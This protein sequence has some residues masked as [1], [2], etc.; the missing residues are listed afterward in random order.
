[1]TDP[2][3]HD[4]V[5]H[6]T[7]VRELD[8]DLVVVPDG[9]VQLVPNIGVI[10][11]RDA[12]L[13]VETGL[14]PRNAEKV[15]EFAAEYARGRRIYLTTTHFH[16]E[17]AFGAQAFTGEATFLVNRA[18]AE[19]LKVKGAG[20][21]DMFRGLGAPV[22]HQLEG[23]VLPEPDLIYDDSYDL[24]LGG[25]VVQLRATGRAHS[26]GDQVVRVPDAGVLFTGDLVEAGQFAIFPWF[27]P[28]DTDVSGTRW[29]AV[30]ERLAGEGAR[31]VV[32]G[33]GAIG[34]PELLADVRDYLRLLRDETWVRRD[35]AM[36]EETIVE[37]VRA[38]MVERHPE[39]AERDWIDKG[40]GCLCAEHPA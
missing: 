28:Y 38:L 37:E 25:R 8:R 13:V 40:V 27:P 21:L 19:D 2:V 39:W 1:M 12:V 4:P 6:I 24:E 3:S 22:A 14:G 35:S 20:Y 7:D 34:G 18:Q 15:L 23:V 9:R 10:G 33:H 5:V 29:I 31:V 36:S 30:M 17:H 16:P 26:K 32:P 11:G